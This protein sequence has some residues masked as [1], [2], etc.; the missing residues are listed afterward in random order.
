MS[1]ASRTWTTCTLFETAF[2]PPPGPQSPGHWRWMSCD[3]T[4]NKCA[5]TRTC[6][7]RRDGC[8]WARE[9]QPGSERSGT[10]AGLCPCYCLPAS[11]TVLRTGPAMAAA[12]ELESQPD[13]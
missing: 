7:S 13:T 5:A 11:V 3:L 6:H 1:S 2:S 8:Q 12:P 9:W 10:C 4:L